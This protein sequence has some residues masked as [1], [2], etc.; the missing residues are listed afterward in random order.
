MSKSS[1]LFRRRSLKL[2]S[3]VSIVTVIAIQCGLFAL[4][5]RW[6]INYWFSTSL[7]PSYHFYQIRSKRHTRHASAELKFNRPII[8][9][10]N[11][12]CLW[13][14][15]ASMPVVELQKPTSYRTVKFCEKRST[16]L[17][18]SDYRSTPPRNF[19]QF[20]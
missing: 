10:R 19:H 15:L 9:I 7:D 14:S 3:P 17:I 11:C 4:S 18:L 2:F 6:Q 1:L 16:T 8:S 20:M 13:S 5:S 12:E